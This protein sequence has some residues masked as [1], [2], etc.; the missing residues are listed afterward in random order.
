[1]DTS[2]PFISRDIPTPDESLV[3]IR[4]NKYRDQDY[5]YLLSMIH[6]SFMSRPNTLVI[7]GGKIGFAMQVILE[8]IITHIMDKKRRAM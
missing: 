6:N 7:P 5:T 4:F 1:V 8:P 2:N 3:V